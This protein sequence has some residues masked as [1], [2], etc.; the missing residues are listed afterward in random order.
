[1]ST[2]EQFIKTLDLQ[3][4]DNIQ[5]SLEVGLDSNRLQVRR[6][7]N[8]MDKIN[9]QG[10]RVGCTIYQPTAL[11]AAAKKI[12]IDQANVIATNT[13]RTV[14]TLLTKYYKSDLF[15]SVE[16]VMGKACTL[17][18][19]D[20]LTARRLI[21]QNSTTVKPDNIRAGRLLLNRGVKGR[22]PLLGYAS[23]EITKLV[24]L[25]EEDDVPVINLARQL[26][27]KEG[28]SYE[29]IP[30]VSEQGAKRKKYFQRPSFQQ[31]TPSIT[32]GQYAI[33]G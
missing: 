16:I 24:T 2:S 25:C 26:S 32:G 22:Y 18:P 4:R 8:L 27:K 30:L 1:M 33:A 7:L 14:F 11:L 15:N 19:A 3:P 28:A 9:D 17:L 10:I 20:L 12:P 29:I 5:L 23:K 13:A 31:T 6:L 21:V